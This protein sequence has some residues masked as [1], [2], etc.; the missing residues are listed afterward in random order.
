MHNHG[1]LDN[2]ENRNPGGGQVRIDT[3]LNPTYSKSLHD[4]LSKI[5]F[6]DGK[7]AAEMQRK[8]DSL[9]SIAVEYN[10]NKTKPV[11]P[12]VRKCSK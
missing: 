3:F 4:D 10:E 5:D 8:Y 12:Q 1:G 9:I 2:P 11:M 6:L 7:N